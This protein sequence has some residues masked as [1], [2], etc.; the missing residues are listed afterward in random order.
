[1][2]GSPL[3]GHRPPCEDPDHSS[4][5]FEAA[6][7]APMHA[8]NQGG[9]AA[10]KTQ[11]RGPP[12]ENKLSLMWGGGGGECFCLPTHH[13]FTITLYHLRGGGCGPRWDELS[14]FFFCLQILAVGTV[15]RCTFSLWSLAQR[16]SARLL[17][18]LWSQSQLVCEGWPGCGGI[19]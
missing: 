18:L 14:F 11:A 15:Q 3:S 10:G 9:E 12:G 13:T 7:R 2:Y 8:G 16:K 5:R 17:L 4:D 6:H 19:I 1:M